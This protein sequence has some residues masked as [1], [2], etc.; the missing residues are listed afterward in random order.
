MDYYQIAFYIFIVLTALYLN[1]I[2][3][4]SSEIIFLY[5]GD[6]EETNYLKKILNVMNNVTIIPTSNS[7]TI[8]NKLNAIKNNSNI[9]TIEKFSETLVRNTL[10]KKPKCIMCHP[11]NM[12]YQIVNKLNVFGY[13]FD[14]KTDFP[15]YGGK[16]ARFLEDTRF[17]KEDTILLYKNIRSLD[18]TNNILSCSNNN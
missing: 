7:E 14:F 12:Y 5:S 2:N 4:N 9:A 6:D 15:I 16:D 1:Y 8:N 3:E 13:P 18:K 10:K 17:V 11:N